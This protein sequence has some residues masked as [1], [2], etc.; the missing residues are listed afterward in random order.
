MPFVSVRPIF[1][2]SAEE[3]L[4][5]FFNISCTRSTSRIGAAIAAV[6]PLLLLRLLLLVAVQLRANIIIIVATGRRALVIAGIDD[7]GVTVDFAAIAVVVA[8]AAAVVV[9]VAVVIIDIDSTMT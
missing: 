4:S 9:A 6:L 5:I 1:R 2:T 8:V 7:G 3:F